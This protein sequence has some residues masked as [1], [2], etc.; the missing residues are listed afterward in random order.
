MAGRA[1]DNV[2]VVRR[3]FQAVERRDLEAM[4][5]L[6]DPEVRIHEAASLPYGG[7]F[8]GFEGVADHGLGYVVAWDHLQTEDDR[9]LEAEFFAV[10]ERV[11][12]RW[13]Q[14]AH[15]ADGSALSVPV[16]SEYQLRDRRVIES[17][18]H[19][20]D[21]AKLAA[22]LAAQGPARGGEHSNAA[23]VRR[24]HEHQGAFYRG[25]PIEPLAE[26][27]ADEVRWHVPGRSA[28]AGD[29]EGRGEVLAYFERRREL[30]RRTFQLEVREVVAAGEL[31][32][33]LVGGVV[34]HEGTK[35]AWETV[36][37][38]RVSGGQIQECRLLPFDQYLFDEIWS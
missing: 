10:G 32:F 26:L 2:D 5:Q 16:I 9:D 6:Y 20:F 27:L 31:V 18:M 14:K 38:L 34:E 12:V 29:Y 24:F 36:G 33:Q 8:E 35:R 7:S 3:L 11:L 17:R 19:S 13:R 15:G 23:L 28:I 21:S 22:F 37:V 25:G 1:E 4:W 30:A